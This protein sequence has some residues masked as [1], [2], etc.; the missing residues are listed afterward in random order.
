MR[1]FIALPLPE[2]AR[3]A[4]A[5]AAAKLQKA[6]PGLKWTRS[7]GYHITLAFLGEISGAS[8]ECAKAAI[9]AAAEHHPLDLCFEGIGGFPPHGPWRVIAG[10]VEDEGEA[11]LVHRSVN[12]SLARHE[13]MAGVGPLNPEWPDGRPFTPH[14][15]IARSGSRG[16]KGSGGAGRGEAGTGAPGPRNIEALLGDSANALRSGRWTIDRCVL[17]SSELRSSGSIYT[18]LK[19]VILGSAVDPLADEK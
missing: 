14:V 11:I 18:E 12:E 7:E 10:M 19:S 3:A 4:L 15:T 5:A 16:G 9:D 13:N 17:Y 8:I 2:G 1:C 6:W